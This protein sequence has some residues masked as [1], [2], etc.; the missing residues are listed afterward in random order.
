V[1][2]SREV[3]GAFVLGADTTVDVDGEILEK[4]RDDD[5]AL[6][7]LARLVGRWHQVHSGVG[8]ARDGALLEGFCV[9][10][11]VH[12]REVDRSTLRR[13]VASGEPRDKAGA[14]AIQGLGSGLVDRM[15]G[16]YTSVVGM[17]VVETLEVLER[18][19]ALA[20][21]PS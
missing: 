8:L 18:H 2:V 17:P 12:F 13:Y 1:S 20:R 19:G 10:S 14:Y 3:P 4:P 15:E 6:S 11:R 5:E 21:W 9:S 7:M 16:S